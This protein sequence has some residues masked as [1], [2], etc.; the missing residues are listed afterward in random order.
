MSGGQIGTVVGG[1]IGAYFGGTVGAQIGMAVGGYIGGAIDPTKIY[2]PKI[3]DGQSQSST[4]GTPI[5]WIQGTARIAGTL[6]AVTKRR[7]VKKKDS[8]KGS[9][10]ENITFEAHQDFAIQICESSELRGTT[11]VGILRIEMDGKIVYDADPLSPIHKDSLKFIQGVDFCYGAEDQQPHPTLEAFFGVGNTLAYRGYLTAVFK[12]FNL[13]PQ[14]DRIPSFVFTLQAANLDSI[15]LVRYTDAFKYEEVGTPDPGP[16]PPYLPNF[17][18]TLW[19]VSQGGF[20][21]QD[22]FGYKMNTPLV[23]PPGNGTTV[24]IRKYFWRPPGGRVWVKLYYDDFGDLWI[25]GTHVLTTGQTSVSIGEIVSDAL[26]DGL[27]LFVYRVFNVGEVGSNHLFCAMDI[28]AGSDATPPTD[29]PLTLADVTVAICERGGLSIENLDVTELQTIP[30]LGYPIAT[31]STASDCLSPLLAAYF[32][33]VSEY[34][35]I[36][37]F[38]TLGA[39]AILTVN[40]LDLIESD[41]GTD[42]ASVISNTRNQETEYPRKITTTYYDPEQNYSAVTVTYERTSKDV[43]AIGEQAFQIPVVLSADDAMAAT[44]K[45]LKATW[46]ALEGTAEY[47][48]PLVGRAGEP[49]LSV[50]SGDSIFF[51]GKRWVAEGVTLSHNMLHLKTTYNRQSAYTTNI[52]AIPAPP[53]IPPVTQVGGPTMLYAMNLPSLRTKDQFGIYLAVGGETSVWAGATVQISYD[54]GETWND[55]V[56]ATDESVMGVLTTDLSTG[57]DAT[58]GVS[59]NGELSTITSGQ[60]AARGNPWAILSSTDIAEV[61]QFRVATQTGDGAYTLSELVRAQNGTA[62]AAHVTGDRFTMLDSVYFFP[63]DL[64]YGETTLQL[65]AITLGG[66]VDEATVISLVYRPDSN[67]I[68]DGGGDP[69]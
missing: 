63:V 8:G 4:D 66:S 50:A 49:Y 69:L 17:D 12:D 10:T 14:G 6:V 59:V 58:V 22:F 34:D 7:Q 1:A 2:G 40:P 11:I 33:Y 55:A 36:L 31:Q 56:T 26:V 24:W 42:D 60:L 5:A 3:G 47:S 18:D 30:V 27:N 43:N 29:R 25:N 68:L 23:D 19:H 57:P 64:A 41:T 48:L 21:D 35:G 28:W 62:L 67:V 38:R 13:T 45:A 16:W 61:G 37:H 9:G 44:V 52:Q 32:C 54:A 46:A 15:T 39:D 20:G 53:P 65:R 51:N